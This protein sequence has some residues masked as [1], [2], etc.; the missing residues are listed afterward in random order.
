[1]T[2]FCAGEDSPSAPLGCLSF[3]RRSSIPAL[4]TQ[5]DSFE[6]LAP[7]ACTAAIAAEAFGPLVGRTWR[8]LENENGEEK[9]ALDG[10]GWLKRKAM[11]KLPLAITYALEG[12]KFH[13]DICALKFVHI[14]E[15]WD[16]CAPPRK[17]EAK[18]TIVHQQYGITADGRRPFIRKSEVS[19]HAV[20]SESVLTY[21]LSEGDTRLKMTTW[22]AYPDM[23]PPALCV[24][25]MHMGA[26]PPA[27]PA[28]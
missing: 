23:D 15:D 24:Y 19:A 13:S 17:I 28:G 5:F 1:M 8:L 3:D 21:E 20:K 22:C 26:D 7:E 6:R 12:T 25:T 27:A 14:E 16:L 9:M 10:E 4:V 18:G 2:T 11:M